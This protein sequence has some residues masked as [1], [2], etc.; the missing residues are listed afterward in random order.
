[1]LLC[2]FSFLLS[3]IHFEVEFEVG[4][5]EIPFTST[6]WKY[7]GT[8]VEKYDGYNF[9]AW[10]IEYMYMILLGPDSI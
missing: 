8:A 5:N 10:L 4:Q 9:C 1:M 3:N 2:V 7:K 6:P